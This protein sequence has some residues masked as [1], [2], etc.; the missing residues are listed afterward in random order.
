M[1]RHIL[2]VMLALCLSACGY[3]GLG[4]SFVG[5]LPEKDG[6]AA[7]AEDAAQYL[8]HEY[9]PGHTTLF[10]LTPEKDAHNAFSAALDAALRVKGFTLTA[11]SSGQAITLA[12]TLD[13]LK[14][15]QGDESAWY[16]QLRLSDGR[17][18]ARSYAPDGAPEAGRSSTPLEPS[19]FR[20]A[21]DKAEGISEKLL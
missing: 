8:A 12:Y 3:R 10:V 1:K 11:E 18:V 2:L 9:A 14:D 19:L 15:E 20:K 13:V 6:T 7:I 16:L 5:S 17:S 4:G 21:S